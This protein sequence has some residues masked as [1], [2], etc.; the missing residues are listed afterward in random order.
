MHG[1]KGSVRSAGWGTECFS[2]EILLEEAMKYL[3][4]NSLLILFPQWRLQSVSLE[5]FYSVDL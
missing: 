2:K 5:E 1:A 3:S 4:P